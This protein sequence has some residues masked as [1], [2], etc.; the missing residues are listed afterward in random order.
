MPSKGHVMG[1]YKTSK[2]FK[3]GAINSNL[4]HCLWDY[5]AIQQ[6]WTRVQK[7]VT[8]S[9]TNFAPYDPTWAIFCYLDSEQYKCAE[10]ARN[11]LHLVSAA[12][13]KTILQTWLQNQQHPL[14][15]CLDKLYITNGLG[16]SSHT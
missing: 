14:K 9:L 11:L 10:G 16:G 8:G 7:C 4:Y 5:P 1:I 13:I 6:F 12:G 15:I 3:C 2:C